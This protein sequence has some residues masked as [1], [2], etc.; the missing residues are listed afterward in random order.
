MIFG[1]GGNLPFKEGQQA[2]GK[3]EVKS[4][5]AYSGEGKETGITMT[6]PREAN[7]YRVNDVT[8]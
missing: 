4:S 3:E 7:D 5:K 8:Q 1:G 6:H 2:E